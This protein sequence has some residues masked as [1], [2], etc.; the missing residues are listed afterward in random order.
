LFGV[1]G[2]ADVGA[3]AG[4]VSVARWEGRA[5]ARVRT[6]GTGIAVVSGTA[7]GGSRVGVVAETVAAAEEESDMK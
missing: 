7:G 4:V 3:P 2:A 1:G 6:F 5:R